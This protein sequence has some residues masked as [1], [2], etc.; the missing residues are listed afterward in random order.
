MHF[1]YATR[2]LTPTRSEYDVGGRRSEPTIT[3]T[4]LDQLSVVTRTP[5]SYGL[6][7][8]QHLLLHSDNI[9]N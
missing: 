5:I 1:A 8:G 2:L 4:W 3:S 6:D 7:I 9:D